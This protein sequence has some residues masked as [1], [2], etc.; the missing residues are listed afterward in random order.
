[1]FEPICA[2]RADTEDTIKQIIG[3]NAAFEAMCGIE[4]HC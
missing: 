1:V 4:V 2:S 3:H